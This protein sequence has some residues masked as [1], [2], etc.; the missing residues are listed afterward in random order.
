MKRADLK[1]LEEVFRF[2]KREVKITDELI[3]KLTGWKYSGFS[4]DNG[5]RIEKGDEKGRESI[6]QCIMSNVFS[7]EKIT[8]IEKTGNVL[9]RSRMQK[10]KNKKNF[11]VYS[12]EEF[13]AAITQHFSKKSF[14]MVRYY[15]FY[16]NKSRG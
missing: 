4:V 13:V 7:T 14:Q 10:G 16:S 5:V 2:L 8:Y 11:V 6:A 3:R 12:A 15:G 1:P 9:C